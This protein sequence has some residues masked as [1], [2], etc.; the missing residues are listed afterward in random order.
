MGLKYSSPD[1][2]SGPH[3]S[4]RHRGKQRGLHSVFDGEIHGGGGVGHGIRPDRKGRRHRGHG[5][6][7]GAGE[8]ASKNVP[9]DRSLLRH[10]PL[11]HPHPDL[12]SL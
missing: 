5:G 7:E 6:S 10:P 12:E 4:G 8:E 2:D 3:D 1:G 11:F 9:V